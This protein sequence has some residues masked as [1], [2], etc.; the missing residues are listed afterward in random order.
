MIFPGLLTGII[1]LGIS[2]I[3]FQSEQS[4]EK[5]LKNREHYLKPKHYTFCQSCAKRFNSIQQNGTNTDGTINTAFCFECYDKGEFI[6]KELSMDDMIKKNSKDINYY[7][8]INRWLLI[9]KIRNL[10]RWSKDKY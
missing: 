8:R 2:L 1:L 5:E 3:A 4:K 10:E 9:K 7:G 6:E